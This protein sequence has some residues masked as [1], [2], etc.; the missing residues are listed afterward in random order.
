MYKLIGTDGRMYGPVTGEQL[1]QWVADGRANA[2][3]LVQPSGNSDWKALGEFPELHLPPLPSDL[4]PPIRVAPRTNGFAV[5]SLVLGAAGWG[6][7]CCGP[8]T[9][10]ISIIFASIALSQINHSAGSQTGRGLACAG[11]G[12]SLVGLL[13]VAT[14]ITAASWLPTWQFSQFSHHGRYW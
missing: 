6:L 7:F 2:Q 4:P 12:L 3:T 1:R 5:A 11:L 9:W 13:A 10:M 8:V 14:W